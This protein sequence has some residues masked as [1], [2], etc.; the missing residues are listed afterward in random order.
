[1]SDYVTKYIQYLLISSFKLITL[2]VPGYDANFYVPIH[3]EP[4][5]KIFVSQNFNVAKKCMVLLQGTGC[6]RAGLWARSVCINENIE[7]GSMYP[8]IER[9]LKEYYSVIIL[10]PNERKGFGNKQNEDIK[11]FNSMQSHCLYVYNNVIS[12]NPNIEE[13]Y[14]VSHSMGGEC[15]IEILKHNEKDLLS[16]KIKKIAFTDSVHGDSYLSLS[17]KAIEQLRQISRDYVTSNKPLG[18]FLKSGK[19]SFNGVDL[20]SSGHVRHEYTS[21][22][23]IKEIFKFFSSV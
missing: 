7:L 2:Y 22:C 23:A 3:T 13:I 1:M 16:G 20:Y 14:F 11:L 12:K 17:S 10:N 4:Q 9:A 15:T 8:Y 19:E 21:G 6:V 5:C 18:T